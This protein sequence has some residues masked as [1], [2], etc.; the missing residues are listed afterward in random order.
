MTIAGPRN[1][2]TRQYREME[3]RLPPEIRALALK[4]F[5]VFRQNPTHPA[6]RNHELHPTR[7]GNHRAESRSVSITMQYRALYV[8]EG[9]FNV[10]YWIGTHADYDAFTGSS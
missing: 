6:L 2:R 7:R 3:S 9:E 10:W 1:V 8:V 4:A 5:E